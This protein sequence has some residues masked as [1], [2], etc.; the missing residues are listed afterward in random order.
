MTG[1]ASLYLSKIYQTY[2]SWGATPTPDPDTDIEGDY[3]IVKCSNPSS[4]QSTLALIERSPVNWVHQGQDIIHEFYL[5]HDKLYNT[6]HQFDD[7]RITEQ[8]SNTHLKMGSELKLFIR[9]ITERYSDNQWLI[10]M[11]L[12]MVA[13]QV[14]QTPSQVKK[15]LLH[16]TMI[17][18]Y[19]V[20]E[21]NRTLAG[22]SA[23]NVD[24]RFKSAIMDVF[25]C[26]EWLPLLKNTCFEFCRH[27]QSWELKQEYY[28][29]VSMATQSLLQGD[30]D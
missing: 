1:Y 9:F 22:I 29:V 20:L 28:Q 15:E 14:L 13:C 27:D 7:C 18:R 26:K 12:L 17:G 30:H 6:C 19:L 10:L 11:G 8:F 16:V 2:A 25:D 23:I 21:M 4:V 5:V 24:R 3:C